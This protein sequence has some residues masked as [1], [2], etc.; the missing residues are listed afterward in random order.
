M[1]LKVNILRR[2]FLLLK[3]HSVKDLKPNGLHFGFLNH[4]GKSNPEKTVPPQWTLPSQQHSALHSP[5][6]ISGKAANKDLLMELYLLQ[7]FSSCIPANNSY[8]KVTVHIQ[9]IQQNW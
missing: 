7:S 6:I 4:H 2:L 8:K 3:S 9:Y 1:F 5:F